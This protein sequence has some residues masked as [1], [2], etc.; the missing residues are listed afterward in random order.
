MRQRQQHRHLTTSDPSHNQI[1]APG[2]VAG[3]SA[4][5]FEY[6]SGD[7]SRSLCDYPTKYPYPVQIIKQTS[8]PSENPTKYS[9]RVP[10][11]LSSANPGNMFIEYPSGY[12]TGA[13]RTMQTGNPSSN[14]ISK[15]I[16]YPD[17]L[18]RINHEAQG[19]LQRNP[20]LSILQIISSSS[21]SQRVNQTRRQGSLIISHIVV[22]GTRALFS[23]TKF[24]I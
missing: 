17:V 24:L 12:T 15:P 10:K 6:S 13:P 8:V 9:S 16:S 11:Q 7:P 19:S 23:S 20:I 4:P 2:G 18:K 3:S 22:H 21:S 14:T 5:G 1:G